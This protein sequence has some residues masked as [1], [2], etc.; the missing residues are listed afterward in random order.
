MVPW[1]DVGN[2]SIFNRTPTFTEPGSFWWH[3]RQ[4][5]A[6]YARSL[7]Y[8]LNALISFVQHYGKKNLVLMVVGDE[9]PLP[10]VSGQGASHDVPISLIAHDRAVL[11]RIT[12]WGWEAGLRPSPQ[13]PVWRMGAVRDRFL[14]AFGPRPATVAPSGRSAVMAS[15]RTQS[16]LP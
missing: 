11:K 6:A 16:V 8:S 5:K 1:N 14:T 13:A 3:P 12:G 4:V 2:G 10:I 9:Q 7:E 15:S